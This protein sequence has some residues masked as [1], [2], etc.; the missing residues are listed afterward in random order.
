MLVFLFKFKN[1]IKKK[2]FYDSFCK[3]TANIPEL[4]LESFN[5]F[6]KYVLDEL[7]NLEN[8]EKPDDIIKEIETNYVM[9]IKYLLSL[10]DVKELTNEEMDELISQDK[11]CLLCYENPSN[12]ELIPCKHR[13]C[14]TC[15]NQYKIDKNICFI[16]QQAIESVNII[17]PK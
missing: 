2:K 12:T 1:G 16:C 3:E 6:I 15:Y 11:L 17:N 8:K 7:K 5:D 13:C 4:N 14:N 9:M 10:R